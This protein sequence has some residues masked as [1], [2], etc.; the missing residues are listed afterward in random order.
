MYLPTTPP[1]PSSTRPAPVR[2]LRRLAPLACALAL[3]AAPAACS[4]HQ[5]KGT[6]AAAATPQAIGASECRACGMVVREQPA[7]RGQVVY[8]DGERAFFCAIGDMVH[9]LETPSPRGAPTQLY[10]EALT[11]D[12]D[13]KQ[14]STSEHRWILA[15]DA[16]YV[17]GVA[18]EG[19]MGKPVLVYA[20]QEDASAAAARYGGHV[21]DYAGLQRALI[22]GEASPE[23][24]HQH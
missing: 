3:S 24:A 8:A 14:A 18:R 23:A 4:K 6:A 7:P 22:H 19:V 16:H 20:S 11:P 21:L 12:E 17:F 15:T 13:P 9:Y 1:P 10:V 5:D 2:L